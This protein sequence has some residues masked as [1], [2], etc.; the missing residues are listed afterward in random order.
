[1][2]DHDELAGALGLELAGRDLVG[3]VPAQV[4]STGTAHLLVPVRDRTAV[5]GAWPDAPRLAATLARVGGQGCYLYSLDPVDPAAVAH[6]RFFNPTVGI[7][8]DPA[9]GS[10]A[11]PLVSRL[12]AQGVVPDGARVLVEQGHAM[13]RPSRIHVQVSGEQV[14]IAGAG[15]VVAEGTLTV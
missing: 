13:G 1:V 6:A 4:V 2:T 14:R 15:V 7:W 11:G 5:D 3:G 10:A 12:V 8:E 9:T